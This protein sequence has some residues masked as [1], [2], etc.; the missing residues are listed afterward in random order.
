MVVVVTAQIPKERTP[1]KDEKAEDKARLDKEF[2]EKQKKFEDKLSQ[3]KSFE[4]WVYLVSN[5]T[6][7]SLLKE[8]AQLLV[9]KKEEPKK[10]EKPAAT[11]AS[12]KE[13]PLALP[14]EPKPDEEK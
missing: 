8:R 13:D 4:K 6:V 10:D 7:D 12:K 5:W 3:E 2:K 11:D 1:G 9:E 14:T